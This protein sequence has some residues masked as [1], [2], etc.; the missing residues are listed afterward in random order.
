MP[1]RAEDGADTLLIEPAGELVSTTTLRAAG[2]TEREAEVLRL[3]ALGRPNAGVADELT[4]S[5]RTVEKHLQNIYEKLGA[6]SR[7]QAMLTAWSIGKVA[8]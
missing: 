1:A 5:I 8:N 4:V 2:L 6:R 7:T 3:V